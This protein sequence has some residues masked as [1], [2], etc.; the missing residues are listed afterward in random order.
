[1]KK[2]LLC[3]LFS[4]IGLQSSLLAIEPPPPEQTQQSDAMQPQE[5]SGPDAYSGT[6]TTGGQNMTN[7]DDAASSGSTSMQNGTSTTG[8]LT[9]PSSSGTAS[10]NSQIPAPQTPPQPEGQQNSPLPQAGQT[11]SAG[12]SSQ[13]VDQSQGGTSQLQACDA[14]T[15]PQHKEFA[16]KLDGNELILFCS[17][18]DDTQRDQ[19]VAYTQNATML[20]KDAVVQVGKESGILFSQNPGGACGGK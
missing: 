14:L 18:F 6:L 8:T 9:D 13:G 15:N 17:I 10:Q 5:P 20:P 1:M 11:P 7:V 4:I 2:H 19:A 3:I 16:K 12:G